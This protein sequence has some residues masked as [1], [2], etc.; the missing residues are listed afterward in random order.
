M[1][2]IQYEVAKRGVITGERLGE[3]F[4]KVLERYG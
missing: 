3:F 2:G 1:M 4:D